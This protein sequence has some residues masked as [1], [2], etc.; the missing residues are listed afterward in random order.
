MGYEWS[1]SSPG[2]STHLLM[3]CTQEKSRRLRDGVYTC[4]TVLQVDEVRGASP[5]GGVNAGDAL[6]GG[7][8]FQR[9]VG[10]YESWNSEGENAALLHHLGE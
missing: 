2:R 8:F 9:E 1:K 5:T 4:G 7:F 3:T 6:E 10:A